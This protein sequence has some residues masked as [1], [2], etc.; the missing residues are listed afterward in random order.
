MGFVSPP[1]TQQPFD[2]NLDIAR[3]QIATR[4][5]L[6]SDQIPNGFLSRRYRLQRHWSATNRE[7]QFTGMRFE[8]WKFRHL[9]GPSRRPILARAIPPCDDESA[10]RFVC[11]DV[12]GRGLL[13]AGA[14]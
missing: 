14:L 1:F 5:R 8:R 11:P 10:I 9:Q 3:N 4:A 13:V 12:R 7:C 2:V 6:I